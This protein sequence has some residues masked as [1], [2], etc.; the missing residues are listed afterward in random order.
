MDI[1]KPDLSHISFLADADLDIAATKVLLDSKNYPRAVYSFE[2]SVEK[3]C[4]YLGLTTMAISYDKLREI[5]HEPEK[6][7]DRIF[8]SEIFLSVYDSID[9]RKLKQQFKKLSLDE[10]AYSARFHIEYLFEKEDTDF[11]PKSYCS[12]LASFYDG[13]AFR[14]FLPENIINE[15]RSCSGIPKA[16]ILCKEFL[17]QIRH[18]EKCCTVQMIMSFLVSGIEANS[19]YPDYN[20]KTTPS[21]IYSKDSEIVQ[22]LYYLIEKQEFCILF[23]KAYF[24]KENILGP[25]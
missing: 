22:N 18:L 17:L 23:L 14:K 9:Y 20:M 10:R 3:S 16:E 2:Q 21:E 6:V 4:K 1:I 5:A 19:R 24:S 25:T 7:F 15:L 8:Q 11:Q 13:N 12:Q